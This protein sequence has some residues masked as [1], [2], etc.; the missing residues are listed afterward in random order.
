MQHVPHQACFPPAELQENAVP[1]KPKL[2]SGDCIFFANINTEK[3]PRFQHSYQINIFAYCRDL[4]T[5]LVAW[6]HQGNNGRQ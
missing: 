6:Q 5:P 2:F 4:Q 3:R 1:L